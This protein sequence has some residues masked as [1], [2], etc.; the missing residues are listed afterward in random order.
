MRGLTGLIA[1]V[2]LVGGAAQALADDSGMAGI[3]AWR[4]VG[5]KTCFVDH[6]HEGS[7]RGSTQRTALAEAVRSWVDFTDLEYGSDWAVYGRSVEKSVACSP[8]AGGFKCDISA[9]PCRGGG[10]GGAPAVKRSRKSS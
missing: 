7:G 4:R 9:I 2:A 5:D 10:A 8:D 3:H 6:S 1:A